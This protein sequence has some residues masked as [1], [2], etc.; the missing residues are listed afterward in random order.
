MAFDASCRKCGDP[1]P[2]ACGAVTWDEMLD[3]VWRK[4]S[5]CVRCGAV[6]D[7]TRRAGWE[8]YLRIGKTLWIE[9]PAKPS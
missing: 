3:I 2:M 9:N 4:S 1:R 7:L 8:W 5:R 6:Y